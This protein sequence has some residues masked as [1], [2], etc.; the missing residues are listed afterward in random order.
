[1][2]CTG[3]VEEKDIVLLHQSLD[4]HPNCSLSCSNKEM[5]AGIKAVL[6]G[7]GKGPVKKTMGA[8]LSMQDIMAWDTATEE[9][10]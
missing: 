3:F 10:R 4:P 2:A 5:E 9:E 7:R 1:M 8:N 6:G